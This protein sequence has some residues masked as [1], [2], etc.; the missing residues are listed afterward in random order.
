AT[1]LDLP[2][3]DIER[4]AEFASLSFPT[5]V[6][7]P[8]DVLDEIAHAAEDVES[9]KR[10]LSRQ[11]GVRRFAV[12]CIQAASSESGVKDGQ[13]F[14]ERLILV[15]RKNGMEWAWCV[16]PHYAIIDRIPPDSVYIV[17]A[18]E[19]AKEKIRALTVSVEEFE[20]RLRIAWALARE[21]SQSDDVLVTDVMK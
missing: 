15:H 7:P 1:G 21:F 6:T 20:R 11:E 3:S 19:A 12:E 5:G 10:E 17:K 18:F 8:K 9:L 13:W 4:K 16:T 14:A 2:P